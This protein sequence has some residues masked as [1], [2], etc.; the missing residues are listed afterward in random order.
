MLL[1][2]CGMQVKLPQMSAGKVS[3]GVKIESQELKSYIDNFIKIAENCYGRSPKYIQLR[4]RLV[5]EFTNK[6]KTEVVAT[7]MKSSNGLSEIE[8]LQS[9]YDVMDHTAV[10]RTVFHEMGHCYLGLDHNESNYDSIMYPSILVQGVYDNY[11]DLAIDELFGKTNECNL[12]HY[13][14]DIMNTPYIF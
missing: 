8:F 5:T 2:S 4:V 11:D 14:E 13:N 10:R 9:Y 7:C 12:Q 1:A 3:K 6:K